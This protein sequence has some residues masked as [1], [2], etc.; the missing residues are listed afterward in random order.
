VTVEYGPDAGSAIA[1]AAAARRLRQK[2]EELEVLVRLEN[3][4]QR[5]QAAF[6]AV[7]RQFLTH[8]CGAPSENSIAE[9][10]EAEAE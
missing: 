1:A 8:G 3:A 6:L 2:Y 4:F 5:R 10:E 9:L 7:H